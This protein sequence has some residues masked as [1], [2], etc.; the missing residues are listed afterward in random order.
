MQTD[1][2]LQKALVEEVKEELKNYTS[3]NNDG[4]YMKFNVYPQNLPA[5]KGKNDD[6]HFPYVLVCLDEEQING[7]DDDLICSIYFLVGINDKNPNK[8]G[9]FDIANVLNRL[10]KRFLEKRL[11]D[12]RYRIAFPLTKKFQEE[13]TYP[14]FIGGMST[15]WTLEKPEIE[16]TE[17]D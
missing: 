1:V 4:E 7:E 10:S 14:K 3:V 16:E 8:Q 15:L 6:E 12:G 11:V 13:D 9:H 5:K 17:Y 2:L